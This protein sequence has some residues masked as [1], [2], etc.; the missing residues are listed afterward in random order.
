LA[1]II[2]QHSTLAK[3]ISM[4]TTI[5]FR[6]HEEFQRAALHMG[7]AGALAGM[8]V[9]ALSLTVQGFGPLGGAWAMA[10]LAGAAAFGAAS[11]STRMKVSE[12]ALTLI[13]A[14]GTGVSLRILGARPIG[15]AVLA[16]GFGL[17]VARGGRRFALTLIAAG[18]TVLLCRFVYVSLLGAAGGAGVP[19]WVAAAATGG[20]F[21]FV[22]VLGL[23]PRHLD[24]ASNRVA[25]AYDA[26]RTV[27]TGEMRELADRAVTLWNKVDATLEPDAAPRKTIEDSI[28]RVLEVGRR[29]AAVEADGARTPTDL[30]AQRMEAMT[31]KMAKT[32]DA[33]AKAQYA[34][35][36]AALAE[37]ARYLKEIA[38]SRERVVARMHHYLA[39]MERLRFAVINHRSADASRLATEVQ[40]ILDDLAHLGTD[41]DFSSEALAEVEREAK[42]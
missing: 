31:D 37:Q 2:V 25:A 6:D 41:I 26:S 40:P 21:A 35:A 36:H 13:I 23:L 15:A 39:A 14:L 9:L 30:L 7:I 1:K 16:I 27:L 33:I 17:L 42:L 22:G 28:V 8:G 11:P 32:D 24:I 10:T 18:A 29:W 38:A 19:L 4:A 12:I 20:A 3:E 34:H 5:R